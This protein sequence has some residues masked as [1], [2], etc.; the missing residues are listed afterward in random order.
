MAR[1]PDGIEEATSLCTSRARS[2]AGGR[3]LT[4]TTTMMTIKVDRLIVPL[5]DE[6]VNA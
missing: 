2:Q 5:L 1:V 3:T 6:L 4:T